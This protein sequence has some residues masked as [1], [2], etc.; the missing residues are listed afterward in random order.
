[1]TPADLKAT[2]ERL[3]LSGDALGSY[4]TPQ[5][6][7]RSV[8]RWEEGRHP[9]PE[10]VAKQ[11]RQLER[12]TDAHV[13]DLAERVRSIS[14]PVIMVYR[15]DSDLH[16]ALPELACYTAEWHRG[17]AKRAALRIGAHLKFPDEEK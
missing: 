12:V 3:G 14:D 7:G 1:M 16:S 4:L 11:V 6:A 17:V 8:R 9:V 5:V 2:R 10:H 13:D 15:V